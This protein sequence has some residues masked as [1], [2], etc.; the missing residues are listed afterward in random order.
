MLL[1][2]CHDWKLWEMLG[3]RH[4]VL[5]A[6]SSEMPLYIIT[7]AEYAHPPVR[8]DLVWDRYLSD[9]V[10]SCTRGLYAKVSIILWGQAFTYYSRY[11]FS[12]TFIWYDLHVQYS[13]SC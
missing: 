4:P 9:C 3:Q 13:V 8:V 10:K 12:L 6:S 1:T 5:A 11:C 2:C 7:F